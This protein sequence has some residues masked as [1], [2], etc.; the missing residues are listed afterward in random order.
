MPMSLEALKFHPTRGEFLFRGLGAFFFV[1]VFLSTLR[2]AS[3]GPARTGELVLLQHYPYVQV[4]NKTPYDCTD[5][6]V[7]YL[8][9][10]FCSN[11]AFPGGTWSASSRDTWL[12]TYITATLTLPDGT[13]NPLWCSPYKSTGT[14]F[15][16]FSIIMKGEDA[17]SVVRV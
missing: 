2:G 9:G 14:S 17:C 16:E 6:N 5:G 3:S 7:I 4:T 8:G 15:S 13:E 12:V 1:V 10:M 11:D